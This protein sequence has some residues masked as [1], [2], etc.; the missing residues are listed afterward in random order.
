MEHAAVVRPRSSAMPE[1]RRGNGDREEMVLLRKRRWV[2]AEIRV[3]ESADASAFGYAFGAAPRCG[4]KRGGRPRPEADKA[5]LPLAADTAPRRCSSRGTHGPEPPSSTR[6]PRHRGRMSAQPG[7]RGQKDLLEPRELH[8]RRRHAA[9]PRRGTPPLPIGI[10]DWVT[11]VSKTD[12]ASEDAPFLSRPATRPSFPVSA[13][14]S[15]CLTFAQGK[16]MQ[17]HPTLIY[18][19]VTGPGF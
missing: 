6:P 1:D 10:G 19:W 3:P 11:V 13:R 8:A 4:G 18:Y 5:P 17:R 12:N 14:K 2:W 7:A 15:P 9:Q 16:P